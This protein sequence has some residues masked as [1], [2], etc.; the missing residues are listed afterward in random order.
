MD[1]RDFGNNR[2]YSR[3]G[4]PYGRLKFIRALQQRIEEFIRD[5]EIL[6]TLAFRS[7]NGNCPLAHRQQD[8]VS[9]TPR[10]MLC[11]ASLAFLFNQHRKLVDPIGNGNNGKEY[12]S[13][14]A[15]SATSETR[16]NR[17]GNF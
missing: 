10:G 9:A 5:G 14:S 7:Q 1:N 17:G 16:H 13:R 11:R 4:I 6:P 3:Q 8:D 15:A 12:R 2:E